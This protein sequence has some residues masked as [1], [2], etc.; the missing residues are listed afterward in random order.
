MHTLEPEL[1]ALHAEGV[2]DGDTAARALAR[3][4]GAVFSLHAEL[5]AALYAGVLLVMGGL[6]I[7]LARNLDRVFWFT[8]TGWVMWNILVSGLLTSSTL[9]MFD[10]NLAHPDLMTL[11]RLAE[12]AR[13]RYFGVSAGFL[14]TCRRAGLTPGKDLDLSE[15]R[16]L[17]STGSPLP[18]EGYDWVYAHVKPDV[19][20]G[21]GSGGTDVATGFV[22]GVPTLPVYAGQMSCRLLGCD[23]VALD[24]DGKAVIGERGEL[25]VKSPMP[26][27]PV[28]FWG[29]ADGSR[30]RAA[31]FEYFP[32]LWR[33]GDWLTITDT[34]TCIITGRSDSTLN[35]GGVRLGTGEFYSVVEELPEIVDS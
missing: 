19:L 29:D 4:R 7:V 34:G 9:V 8:T 28:G 2:I 21:S 22:G 5:R 30:L 17:G 13:V 16:T 33:H 20:L 3:D 14:L 15:L 1:R 10:G 27:M 11:W 26:S 35:R 12:K 18:L 32:G 25:V 23:V 31:Y 24:P 6:G